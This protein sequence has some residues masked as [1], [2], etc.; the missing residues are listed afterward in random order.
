MEPKHSTFFMLF[1]TEPPLTQLGLTFRIFLL[2]IESNALF[3]KSLYIWKV[4]LSILV[5]SKDEMDYF[6]R[7]YHNLSSSQPLAPAFNG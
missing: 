6:L 7:C 1:A 5:V 3:Q 2:E 4:C